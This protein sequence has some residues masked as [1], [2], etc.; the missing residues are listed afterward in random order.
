MV[1]PNYSSIR[2]VV[3]ESVR[4]IGLMIHGVEFDLNGGVGSCSY[5]LKRFIA[6]MTRNVCVVSP[7]GACGMRAAM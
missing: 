4:R 3:Q 7:D 6:D 1:A 2:T 5:K